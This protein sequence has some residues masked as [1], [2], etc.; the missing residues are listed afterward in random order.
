MT[1]I[2]PPRY[3]AYRH[4]QY[5]NEALVEME[6]QNGL[7]FDVER[8]AR[9]DA[10]FAKEEKRALS[11]VQALARRPTLNANSPLQISDVLNKLGARGRRLTMSGNESTDEKT[12]E[13]LKDDPKSPAK[14]GAFIDALLDYRGWMKLRGTYTSQKPG[15]GL[16]SH[17]RN[18]RIYPHLSITTAISGRFASEEPNL[19]NI[20]ARNEAGMKIRSCFRAPKGWSLIAADLSQI[21]LRIAAHLSNDPVMVDAFK[22]GKDLHEQTRQQI[23]ASDP[24]IKSKDPKIIDFLRKPSKIVN[25]STLN[26]ISPNG[27]HNQFLMAGVRDFTVDDC[28]GFIRGFWKL[29]RGLAD[30]KAETGKLLRTQGYVETLGGRRRYLP[31]A[32]LLEFES[33]AAEAV[34]QGWNHRIQGSAAETLKRSIHRWSMSVKE[35]ANKILPTFL[36]LQIHDELLW[37][38]KAERADDPKVRALARTLK[39]ML[40]ADSKN[41]RVPIIAEVKFGKSW[42]EMEKIKL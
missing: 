33:I 9:V 31:L 21:E 5:L 12:L 28:D 3:A 27:L 29:Y 36:L 42:G 14:L 39:S 41:Y 25:F 17:V 13:Q 16:S 10:D 15:K 8:C 40:E 2:L 37:I 23:F 11:H 20:P 6:V 38:T 4:D 26:D 18:G 22:T 30:L 32:R 34:R 19:Q 24:R 1:A 35:A 7:P